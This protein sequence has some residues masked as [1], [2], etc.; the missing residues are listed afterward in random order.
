MTTHVLIADDS[1]MVRLQVQRHFEAISGGPYACCFAGDGVQAL[2]L[3]DQG[4]IDI[5][6][7]DL[8]MPGMDGMELLRAIQHHPARPRKVIVM[9]SAVGDQLTRELMKCDVGAVIA[10]PVSAAILTATLAQLDGVPKD[11]PAAERGR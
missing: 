8:N 5:L 6:L 4:G 9:T 3:I 7:A 1:L 10:K 11:R 2:E